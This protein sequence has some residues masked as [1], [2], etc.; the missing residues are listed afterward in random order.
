MKITIGFD[1]YAIHDKPEIIK[2][3]DGGIIIIHFW[4]VTIN[5]LRGWYV[6]KYKEEM[7]KMNK[8]K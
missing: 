3:C 5:I 6:K 1:K 2:S 7:E 8:G 4:G